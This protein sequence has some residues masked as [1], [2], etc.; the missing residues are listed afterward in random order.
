MF[1]E[2]T[3]IL[4]KVFCP[5][6]GIIHKKE[7]KSYIHYTLYIPISESYFIDIENLL[8]E[9]P[10]TEREIIFCGFLHLSASPCSPS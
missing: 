6:Y 8:I 4:C 9:L 2:G 7:K 10:H 3:Q 1:F 5:M